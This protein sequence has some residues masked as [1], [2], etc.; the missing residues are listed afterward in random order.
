MGKI[1]FYSVNFIE[2][3]FFVF[4]LSKKILFILQFCKELLKQFRDKSMD[5]YIYIYIFYYKQ[6]QVF[7]KV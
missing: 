2:S 1:L 4:K 3:L 6:K 5:I 7:D